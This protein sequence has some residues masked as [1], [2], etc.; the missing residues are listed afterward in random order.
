VHGAGLMTP[1]H[2]VRVSRPRS[3]INEGSRSF[4][5]MD[6]YQDLLDL[7]RRTKS[8]ETRGVETWVRYGVNFVV[9]TWFCHWGLVLAGRPSSRDTMIE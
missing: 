3:K 8:G 1:C 9:R 6:Y 7:L 4:G 2:R 5:R